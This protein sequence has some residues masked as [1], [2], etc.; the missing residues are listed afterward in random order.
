MPCGIRTSTD[1]QPA[2]VSFIAYLNQPF[3]E[4]TLLRASYPQHRSAYSPRKEPAHFGGS[5]HHQMVSPYSI[6]EGSWRCA[7]FLDTKERAT[8]GIPIKNQGDFGVC[9]GTRPQIFVHFSRKTRHRL[10]NPKTTF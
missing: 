9:G 2:I 5:V 3:N 10:K 4:G 7:E 6:S 8:T 1:P